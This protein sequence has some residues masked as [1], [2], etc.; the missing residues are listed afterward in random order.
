MKAKITSDGKLRIWAADERTGNTD[1]IE[2]PAEWM[3][4]S[5]VFNTH[6]ASTTTR[7]MLVHV[8]TEWTLGA[9]WLSLPEDRGVDP[10]TLPGLF[11]ERVRRLHAKTRR[12]RAWYRRLWR[13]LFQRKGSQ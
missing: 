8:E 7:L 12:R 10:K 1:Q 11:A 13:F 6:F 9:V 3:Q 2:S 4:L 5:A